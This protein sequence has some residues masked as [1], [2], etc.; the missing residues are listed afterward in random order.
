MI[1]PRILVL[2][3]FHQNIPSFIHLPKHPQLHPST[4][5]SPA[6]SIYQHIPNFI[7]VPNIS[8]TS[9]IYPTHPQIHTFTKT[10]PASYIYQNIPV[11]K[12]KHFPRNWP[13]VREIHRSTVN[14]PHKGQWRGALMFSLTC[15][16]INDWVNNR[17]AGDLRRYLAHY[18][19]ITL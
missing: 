8:P 7:H 4:K 3:I 13:F 15:V 2:Q 17:E 12:W 19:V 9:S 11:I 10:S 14:S 5:T 6:S 1:M 16:W 18:D